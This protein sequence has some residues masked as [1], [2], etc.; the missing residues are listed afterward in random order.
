[1]DGSTYAF[2]GCGSIAAAICAG[3]LASGEV[4][5]GDVFAYDVNPEAR[6]SFCDSFGANS[7]N[8]V[9]GAAERA[10]LIFLAVKPAVCALVVSEIAE[11]IQN[12]AIGQKNGMIVSL[13]AGVTLGSLMERLPDGVPLARAMPN[14]NMASRAGVAA[15]CFNEHADE[16]RRERARGFFRLVGSVFELAEAEFD[17]FTTLA[18]CAPAYTY[19]FIDALAKGAH[20]NGMNKRLATRIAAETVLGSARALLESA[21]SG[22]HAYQMTDNVCSPGGMTIKGVCALDSGAFTGLVASAVEASLKG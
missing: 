18:G 1:M 3:A 4:K 20:K 17:L 10:D 14:L 21:E 16:A 5:G 13:A 2:I 11:I 7:S 6:R 12:G 19:M 15:L 22:V 9:K 8:G